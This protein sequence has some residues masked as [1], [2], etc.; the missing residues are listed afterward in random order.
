[1]SYKYDNSV[2]K[3]LQDTEFKT[4]KSLD[5]IAKKGVLICQKKRF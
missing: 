2:L 1:M 5:H 4:L 3:K